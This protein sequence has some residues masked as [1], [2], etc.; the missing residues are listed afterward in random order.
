MKVL[1]IIGK[2]VLIIALVLLLLV[3][4]VAGVVAF[5]KKE[6][7]A[8]TIKELNTYLTAKVDVDP[9]VDVSI[10][11]KFPQITLEFKKVKI[12]ESIE[13]SDLKL[14]EAGEIFLAFDPWDLLQK[15]YVISQLYIE[16]GKIAIR[17]DAQ[18]RA[19]YEIFKSDTTSA[20]EEVGFNLKKIKLNNVE[21]SFVNEIKNQGYYLLAK[22]LAAKIKLEQKKYNIGL[23]GKLV[24]HKIRAAG[25]DYFKEKNLEIL[26]ELIL[27]NER[28]QFIVLPSNLK[29]E[30]SEFDLSGSFSYK[31]KKY[32][33]FEFKG[34]KG[35]IQTLVS[36]MPKK[37]AENFSSYASSGNIFFKST[38]KG[39]ISETISPLIV[40][41]FGISNASIFHPDYK[42]RLEK[43]NLV[44]YFSNGNKHHAKTS[45]LKLS[46]ISFS[47]NNKP[48]KGDFLL[49]NFE[50]PFIRFK[51]EGSLSLESIFSFYPVEKIKEATGNLDFDINFTGSSEELRKNPDQFN[52]G[53]QVIASKINVLV[54][55]LPYRF[56]NISGDFLFNNNDIAVNDFKGNIGRSDFTVNGLFKNVLARLFNKKRKLFVDADFVSNYLDVEELLSA[57]G[58]GAKKSSDDS[59]DEGEEKEEK[60]FPFFKKYEVHLNCE[61]EK[62]SYKKFHAK[63]V[64]GVYTMKD[65]WISLERA[66]CRLAGGKLVVNGNL[67]FASP[68]NIELTSETVLDGI[69]VDSIFYMCDNFDQKFIVDKNLKGEITGNVDLF[70]SMNEKFSIDDKSVVAKVEVKI[71]NGELNNFE[72]MQSLSRFIEEKELEHVRFSELKNTIYIENRVITIPEMTIVTNVSTISVSGTHTFDHVMD[73]RLTV[74]LKNFKRKHKDK[75]EAFGAIEDDKRGQS[76]VFLTVKGTTDNYKIAYDTK[77]TKNKIKEDIKKEKRELL[78]I[79]KPKRRENISEDTQEP[80]EENQPKD[81]G[82]KFFDF[83]D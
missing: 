70:M 49:E 47:L 40:V 21:L 63:K 4:I 51:A 46:D 39:E 54:D 65:P 8:L 14:V 25:H 23:D 27:D 19:N 15:R 71:L 36:L 58:K 9:D 43:V 11:Q 82:P 7:I 81:D 55:N 32:I 48:V 30:K 52:A 37:I 17:T 59:Q 45:F 41:E 10:F 57:G 66:S 61:I 18:G 20:S 16:D 12:A 80:I 38:V 1:R 68:S 78:D 77:R 50:N 29:V 22:D 79:F 28:D 2:V 13:G 6:I 42:G 62:F 26:S 74:P 56:S 76:V 44:G 75:D 73:Y 34:K 83:G 5:Y 69:Q 64:K 24:S 53:G 31:D 3:G 35:Q 33:D 60:I 67:N 72:P